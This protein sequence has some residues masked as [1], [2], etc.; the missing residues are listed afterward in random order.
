MLTVHE[1]NDIIIEGTPVT[2][3]YSSLFREKG[4]YIIS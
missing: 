2:Y 1:C 4:V 3:A